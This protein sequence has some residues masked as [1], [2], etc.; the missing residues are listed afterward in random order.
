MLCI[1]THAV[2]QQLM[3]WQAEPILRIFFQG[4]LSKSSYGFD[5]PQGTTIGRFLLSTH[6]GRPDPSEFTVAVHGR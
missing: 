2:Q 4:N 3:E 6:Q 5:F 1:A